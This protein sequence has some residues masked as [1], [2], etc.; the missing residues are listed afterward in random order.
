MIRKLVAVT[1]EDAH[2]SGAEMYDEAGVAAENPWVCTTFGLLVRD[3][4][5]RV[6]VAAE[7]LS[8]GNYRGLTFI[9]RAMIR[10]IADLGVWPRPP[11]R[12]RPTSPAPSPVQASLSAG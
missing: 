10:S 9:P 1:W 12:K 8:S 3:D 6:G 5:S 7:A 4:E 11:R 2:V